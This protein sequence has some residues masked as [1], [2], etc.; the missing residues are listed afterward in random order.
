MSC[1]ASSSGASPPR[2]AS[3]SVKGQAIYTRNRQSETGFV[4][5][6]EPRPGAPLEYNLFQQGLTSSW[7]LDLFGRVRRAVEAAD[8]DTL[9]SV[10]A[11]HGVAVSSIA[12]LAQDYMQLRGAQSRVAI[13]ERNLALTRQNTRSGPGPLQQR[14]GHHA[15]SGAGASAGGNGRR[16]PAP[17][18]GRNRRH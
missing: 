6:V 8:A 13:T 9:A 12:E 4:S 2:K 5:L 18:C 3:R 7:E 14:G 11:R 10:E 17:A 16:H 1:K 15:R